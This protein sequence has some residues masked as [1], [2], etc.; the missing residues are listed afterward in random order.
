[1]PV[2]ARRTCYSRHAESLDSEND[3]E[4]VE[5]V[6]GKAPTEGHG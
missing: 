5:A 6:I 2:L 3:S 4:A 1:V